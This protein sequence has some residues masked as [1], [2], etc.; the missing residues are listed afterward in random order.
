VVWRR[1]DEPCAEYGAL[2]AD[3][4]GWQL[5]GTMVGALDGTPVNVRY[6]VICDE[7]WSTLAAHLTVRT[8][9]TEE[10]L[11]LRVDHDR[12]WWTSEEEEL[13]AVRGCVDVDLAITPATNTLPIR[14][15]G[16][17]V[18][19]SAEV[20]AAWVRF[21]DLTVAPLEQTYTRLTDTRYSYRS[22]SF[23]AE[24]DVDDLG[25]IREYSHGWIREG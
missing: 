24:L 7:R 8:G 17:E 19:A 14:R 15:L 2:W 13:V 10:I 16:L 1:L 25:L 12:R 3:G 5:R 18:G 6:G 22:N 4:S 9:A 20:R 11:H 23:H 21:P